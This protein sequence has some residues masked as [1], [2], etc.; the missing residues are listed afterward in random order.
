MRYISSIV[1]L[2]LLLCSGIEQT[3]AQQQVNRQR[4]PI[5]DVHLHAYGFDQFGDPPPP[6]EITGRRPTARTDEEALE[7]TLAEMKRYNIVKAVVSGP[8]KDVLR[9]REAA[10]D[11]IIGGVY[12]ASRTALPELTTLRKEFTSGRL[13]VMGELGLQYSGMAPNDPRLEPYFALA[14]EL[15]IPVGIHTGLGPRRA[16]YEGAPKFRVTLGNPLLLEEVLIR[17]PKLRLYIMHAG[18]PYLQEMIAILYMYPQV[19]ADLAVIN[20]IIPREEF[21]EYLRGLM[22]AGMGK[23]LMFGSDQMVWP[24]AIGL[25]VEGIES[26][27][28]LTEEQKRDIFYSNAARFLRLNR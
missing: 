24:E 19:Y 7:A 18:Y 10:P 17:H 5:I 16:P 23:R 22:R 20:W 4:P 9:W 1:L 3:L 8:L 28:F 25:A 26:A 15:D 6:N 27:S 11:R 14:E 12:T 13:G 2:L 21:H